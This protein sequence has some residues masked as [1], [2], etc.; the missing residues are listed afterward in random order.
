M[1][2]ERRSIQYVNVK[3]QK[4]SQLPQPWVDGHKFPHEDTW[5]GM[6]VGSHMVA[7]NAETTNK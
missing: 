4:E 3:L 2:L 1:K 7:L 5:Q 6:E